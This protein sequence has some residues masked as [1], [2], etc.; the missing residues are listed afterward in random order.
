MPYCTLEEAWNVEVYPDDEKEL[1]SQTPPPEK[2]GYPNK[3]YENNPTPMDIPKPRYTMKEHLSEFELEKKSE[4]SMLPNSQYTRLI[5]ELKG[6]NKKLKEKI[7]ELQKF[8]NKQQDKD[9][10]FDV[11]LYISTGIFVIFMMDNIT[12]MGRRY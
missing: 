11:I 1:V 12:S 9:S 7:D 2:Y 5:E 6:E 4:L 10:L 3:I 8:N